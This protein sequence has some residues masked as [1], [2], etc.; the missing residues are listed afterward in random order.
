MRS[1]DNHDISLADIY[2]TQNKMKNSKAPREDGAFTNLT[3]IKDSDKIICRNNKNIPSK[4]KNLITILLKKGKLQIY[5]KN[6]HLLTIF[7]NN[8]T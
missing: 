2:H 7:E 8:N 4:A 3:K 1:D 5:L 6:D